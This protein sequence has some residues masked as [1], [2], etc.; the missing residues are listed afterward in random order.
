[1]HIKI[2]PLLLLQSA[3]VVHHLDG[4]IRARPRSWYISESADFAQT[5]LRGDA[6][7]ARS[8]QVRPTS[9]VPSAGGGKCSFVSR[10]A[11]ESREHD[12]N[13]PHQKTEC[14]VKPEIFELHQR[15]GS[16][17]PEIFW[18]PHGPK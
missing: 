4:W 15:G 13:N 5:N 18:R 9:T 3:G 8:A 7:V 10:L 2:S 6:V 12:H 11:V 1:M 14:V 17:T 16:S